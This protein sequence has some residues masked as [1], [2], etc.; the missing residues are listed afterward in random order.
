MVKSSKHSI[1]SNTPINLKRKM[2]KELK[3]TAGTSLRPPTTPLGESNKDGGLL[4]TLSPPVMNL[5][6]ERR[7]RQNREAKQ[8]TPQV[9]R[10]EGK[11][12]IKTL[13][14]QNKVKQRIATRQ[15]NKKRNPLW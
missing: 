8:A 3:A 13:E 12:W 11:R 10:V 9:A 5:S 4:S 15:I 14:K 6:I 7:N 1:F 2:K